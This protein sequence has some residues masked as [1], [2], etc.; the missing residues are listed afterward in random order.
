[1]VI[2]HTLLCLQP[3]GER[4]SFGRSAIKLKQFGCTIN[5]VIIFSAAFSLKKT[6]VL[7]VNKRD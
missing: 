1:M 6:A 5:T 4:S 3:E 7:F 2:V